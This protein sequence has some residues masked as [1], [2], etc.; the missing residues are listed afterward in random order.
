MRYSVATP[1]QSNEANGCTPGAGG[2]YYA[3]LGLTPFESNLEI[4]SSTVRR[5]MREA[6]KYQLGPHAARTQSR[7]E[8]LADATA[9][10]LDPARKQAYDEELRRQYGMPPVMIASTYVAPAVM[11]DAPRA[12][13]DGAR[14]FRSWRRALLG[15]MLVAVTLAMAWGFWQLAA[16]VRRVGPVALLSKPLFACPPIFP[17]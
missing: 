1:V 6:R 8:E 15:A 11:A 2:D 10:L 9:C 13:T 4:I 3:L 14:R 7:M 5:Q 16:G 12:P 17:A